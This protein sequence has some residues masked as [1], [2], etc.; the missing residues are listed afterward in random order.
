[1][2]KMCAGAFSTQRW[3]RC[4]DAG[5]GA[6][7]DDTH[8]AEVVAL[9][10]LL[11][12]RHV[13][14]RWKLK[15]AE[16]WRHDHQALFRQPRPQLVHRAQVRRQQALEHAQLAFGFGDAR[17]GLV[18]VAFGR[19]NGLHQF[20]R[21]RRAVG[22]I[23]CQ[24]PMQQRGSAARKADDEERP[25]DRLL[26][27]LGAALAVLFE[28]QALLEQAQVLTRA[29]M[30]P[31]KVRRDSSSYAQQHRE[32]GAVESSPKSES[33]CAARRSSSSTGRARPNPTTGVRP[34]SPAVP[35]GAGVLRVN[36]RGG[37][38]RRCV[39]GHHLASAMCSTLRRMRSISSSIERS[40][41]RLAN[42]SE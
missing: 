9:H 24:Q 17:I 21:Q 26:G 35:A 23:L 18:A 33:P 10:P 32:R 13:V 39:G 19:R 34:G 41:S 29:V 25:L 5:A 22:G 28:P 4:R 16:G 14:H 36:Q 42:W 12:G 6:R 1:M 11:V 3:P 8:R 20:P 30:R 7:G 2:P 31:A 15:A 37:V 38:R 40:R 27:D